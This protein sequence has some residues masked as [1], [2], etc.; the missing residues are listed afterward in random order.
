MISIRAG[1]AS[2]LTTAAILVFAAPALS[3]QAVLTL[4]SYAPATLPPVSAAID[5]PDLSN[6]VE[7]CR[8]ACRLALSNSGW[9]LASYGGYEWSVSPPEWTGEEYLLRIPGP[10]DAVSGKLG[11][12]LNDEALQYGPEYRLWFHTDQWTE[13]LAHQTGETAD[14]F[15]VISGVMGGVWNQCPVPNWGSFSV[16]PVPPTPAPPRVHALLVGCNQETTDP[17]GIPVYYSGLKD[18]SRLAAA[19]YTM[20]NM[21]DIDTLIIDPSTENAH[22]LVRD[23]IMNMAQRVG[24]DETFLLFIGGHGSDNGSVALQIGGPSLPSAAINRSELTNWLSTVDP[25]GNKIVILP[26]CH[27][28]S[29]WQGTAGDPGLATLSR[30]GLLAGAPANEDSFIYPFPGD[31]FGMSPLAITV[32]EGL[33]RSATSR[34]KADADGSGV[35]T[36]DELHGF[37]DSANTFHFWHW[38][39][40][41]FSFQGWS[42]LTGQNWPV[43]S[44]FGDFQ[45]FAFTPEYLATTD[46]QG[47]AMAGSIPEPATLA[48]LALGGLALIRRRRTA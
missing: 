7:L 2:A 40:F 21:G 31:T 42:D 8:Q 33:H 30:I 6:Q 39:I 19:L 13:R 34:S 27:T 22:D 41:P 38:T 44:E 36:F 48:L 14:N 32:I 46:I 28:G 17:L 26:G 10:S 25:A 1:L 11:Y 35:I 3:G 29:F 43:L 45:S 5:I 16:A 37:V 15:G 12:Q 18:A 47:V 20:P 23:R 24:P 4:E 9:N